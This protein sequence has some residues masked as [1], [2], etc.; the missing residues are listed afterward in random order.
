VLETL[1]VLD[2]NKTVVG[3]ECYFVLKMIVLHKMRPL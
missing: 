3:R 1:K 2:E